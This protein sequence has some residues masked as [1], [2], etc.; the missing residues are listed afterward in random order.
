VSF[1]LDQYADAVPEQLEEAS[2]KVAG[3]LS[4]ARGSNLVA[5]PKIVD[6]Q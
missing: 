1:T 2:E 5:A 4:S 3:V 6:A